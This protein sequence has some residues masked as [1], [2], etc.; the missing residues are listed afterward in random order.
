MLN[1]IVSIASKQ[2]RVCLFNQKGNFRAYGDAY[3]SVVGGNE[4]Y[5][6]AVVVQQQTRWLRTSCCLMRDKRPKVTQKRD[7]GAVG[8]KSLDIDRSLRMSLFPDENTPSLVYD[9]VRFDDLNILN[10]KVTKN[11]TIMQLID[12]KGKSLILNSCG[13]EGFKNAK[14]GTNVAAQATGISMGMKSLNL[15]VRNVRV[16]IRGLGPGRAAS[17]KGLQMAGINIVSITDNTPAEIT[18]PRPRKVRR[19]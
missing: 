12:P 5:K 18:C 15:G 10:I 4:K 9:G 3:N 7:E 16:K 8:E 13:N 1:S 14:K 17:I 2:L 19:V 11:N 6:S